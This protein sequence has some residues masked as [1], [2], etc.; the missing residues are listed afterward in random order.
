[1]EINIT[2]F[3]KEC[4]P[5]DFS[6]SVAEIGDMAGPRTWRAAMEE[7]LDSQLLTT[8]DEREALRDH[9]R[10]FGAWDDEEISGWSDQQLNAL[11]IQLISGDM[12]EFS[13]HPVGEWS[14]QE[15]EAEAEAGRNTG[16]LFMA[17]GEYYYDLN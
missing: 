13:D 4:T 1:M 2:K 12:R 11:F 8:D 16:R 3:V 14:W 10:G 15:Y 9:V 6:A 5:K 7:A 17:D